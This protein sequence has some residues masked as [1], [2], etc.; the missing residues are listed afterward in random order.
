VEAALRAAQVVHGG[1]GGG[2][3]AAHLK[4]RCTVSR[5]E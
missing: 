4:L 1:R 3:G 2:G 5:L